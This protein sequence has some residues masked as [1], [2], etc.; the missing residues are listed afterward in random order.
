MKT[1][2]NY[3]GE[4]RLYFKPELDRCPHCGTKLRRS[5]VIWR[6][7]I[8]TIRGIFYVVSYA[9]RCPHP[10][11]PRPD[12][13]YCS[14]E[15]ER[16]SLKY[17]QVGIDVIAEVGNLRFKRH[18]TH[19]E[20][21][22]QLRRRYRVAIS[23]SEV[24][25]LTNVYLIL[26]GCNRE[27][28]AELLERLRSNG[29]ITLSIDGIQPEKGNETLYILRDVMTGEVLK[30]RNLSS[31]DTASITS[32]LE[33]VRA[34]GVPVI[35]VVSDAHKAIRLAVETV[36]PG[37]PHQYCHY[38]YLD[39]AAKPVSE[40]DRALKKDLKRRVR[41]IR[42]VERRAKEKPGKRSRLVLEY[43]SAIRAAMQDD[44]LYPLKPGGLRLYRRL[45]KI[46]RSMERSCNTNPHRDLDRL[47][48]ILSVLDL[49]AS[50]YRR[51]RRLH[52]LVAEAAKTLG[53]KAEGE[54]AKGLMESYLD[55]LPKLRY[56][57]D[58]AAVENIRRVTASFWPGLFHCY[59]HPF[60]PATNNALEVY[61]RSLK[62]G[63]RKT[64]GRVGCQGHILRYGAYVVHVDFS[65][66]RRETVSRFQSVS[67]EAFLRKREEFES[68]QERFRFSCRVRRN[69]DGF[70]RDQEKQWASAS[71]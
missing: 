55:G 53:V 30:A 19:R 22:R 37:V 50:R 61:I 10:I 60:L 7:H 9:Y 42:A 13:R 1:R 64:T 56:L 67:Y 11:C 58:K 32:L 24:R 2:R 28:D 52:R 36:F 17:Y 26:I 70:L 16:L 57:E 23:T 35:G 59:D 41:G 47:I 5:Y 43:C 12:E 38:H 14:I 3:R 54:T 20:I 62:A 4:K 66:S 31:N 27:Q 29:G 15:A 18:L 65:V 51:I 44:G 69:L 34:M 71:D 21:K 46:R 33:D 63:Y 6:K 68:V 48:E 8:I 40:M 25:L 45:M 39:D 49:E